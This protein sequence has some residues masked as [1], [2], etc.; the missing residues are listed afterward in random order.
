MLQEYQQI[1]LTALF[2]QYIF[3]RFILTQNRV[4]ISYHIINTIFNIYLFILGFSGILNPDNDY[5]AN[6]IITYHK[7][8]QIINLLYEIPRGY[9]LM[10]LHHL[11]LIIL[12]NNVSINIVTTASVCCLFI[13]V[14]ELTST[15][16]N[17]SYF[18][19]NSN[20]LKDR[21]QKTN[22]LIRLL[23]CFSFLIIRVFWWSSVGPSV[24]Y[25]A[26]INDGYKI[27]LITYPIFQSMQYYWGLT[28]IRK[29]NKYLK[30]S[31]GKNKCLSEY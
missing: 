13:G 5:Y 30:T 1:T 20:Y 24:M 19:H 22:M 2:C 25:R 15:L 27:I 4:D 11:I 18:I 29:I 3:Y 9:S 14:P 28:I 8:L 16:Y 12:V 7:S 26:Y 10:L 21:F 6:T 31:E 17:I 23:F